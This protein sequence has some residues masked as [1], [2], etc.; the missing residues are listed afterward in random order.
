[1]S[2]RSVTSFYEENM[3]SEEDADASFVSFHESLSD[4]AQ[5]EGFRSLGKQTKSPRT[6]AGRKTITPT[7]RA[8]RSFDIVLN[9]I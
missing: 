9:T 2:S 7:H 6:Y 5:S 8:N 1:M 3:E 4:K